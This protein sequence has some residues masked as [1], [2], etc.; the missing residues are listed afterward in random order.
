LFKAISMPWKNS[1]PNQR[2]VIVKQAPTR[3]IV[4]NPD[5]MHSLR[6]ALPVG[7]PWHCTRRSAHALELVAQVLVDDQGPGAHAFDVGRHDQARSLQMK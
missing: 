2:L 3:P 1:E 6:P 7:T 5:I 4:K